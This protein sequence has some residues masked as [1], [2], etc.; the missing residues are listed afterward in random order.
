MKIGQISLLLFRGRYSWN[1]DRPGIPARYQE[2]RPGIVEYRRWPVYRWNT[3][4]VFYQ[5]VRAGRRRNHIE[6][7]IDDDGPG[8]PETERQNAFRPFYRVEESRN[9]ET[10][11]TGLGL[12]IAR[13]IAR[14]FGGELEIGTSALDGAAFLLKLKR[15]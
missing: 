8:I 10:G 7:I 6:I 9:R 3:G 4:P 2:Y 11:G 12:A 5:S 14:E 15:A 1:T 13:D